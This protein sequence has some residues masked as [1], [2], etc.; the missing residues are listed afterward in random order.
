MFIN[1]FKKK[2]KPELC[3]KCP[4]KKKLS[5]IQKA[6]SMQKKAAKIYEILD[7]LRYYE[8]KNGYANITKPGIFLF[9]ATIDDSYLTRKRL[10]FA[11]ELRNAANNLNEM[12]S[13]FENCDEE[14]Q[15]RKEEI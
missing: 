10:K 8:I 1:L 14:Y 6:I 4:D 2:A 7:S 9:Y 11:A 13:V 15:K 12:A 3:D 5:R